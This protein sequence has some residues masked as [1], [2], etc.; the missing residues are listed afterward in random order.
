MPPKPARTI[1]HSLSKTVPALRQASDI[2]RPFKSGWLGWTV[3]NVG[4][5]PVESQMIAY[6][7]GV[8]YP[9]FA[10]CPG[11]GAVDTVNQSFTTP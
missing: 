5:S 8:W 3:E 11:V 2:G 10:G 4:L 9:A 1:K 7:N 6:P